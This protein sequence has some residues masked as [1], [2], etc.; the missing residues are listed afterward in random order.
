MTTNLIMDYKNN[1]PWPA[2][3]VRQY[4]GLVAY[5]KSVEREYYD[6]VIE[7]LNQKF[8]V[9]LKQITKELTSF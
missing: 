8:H 9:D 1:K 3:E 4:K 6:S 2:D 7:R 5:Y